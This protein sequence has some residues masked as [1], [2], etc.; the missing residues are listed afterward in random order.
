MNAPRNTEL[1]IVGPA[2]E[3]DGSRATLRID[4]DRP[5]PAPPLSAADAQALARASAERELDRLNQTANAEQLALGQHLNWLIATQAILIHAFLMLFIVSGL[6]VVAMNQW[7][8]GGLAL[9]G[10]LCALALHGSI[11]RAS[12]A[13]ALLIVHRR[14]AE[15]ELAALDG[16]KPT[17]PREV[18]R[19][20]SL[21]G[22]AFV[23]AWLLLLACS[24]ALRL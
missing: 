22:P 15:A 7:M 5:V 13:L 18:S 24:A 20:D 9:L 4:A 14:A 23:A 1:R 19:V 8:L 10:I 21:A 11:D 12:R 3:A 16:R 2:A 17:L 6:G